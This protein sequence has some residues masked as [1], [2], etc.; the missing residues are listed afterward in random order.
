MKLNNKA[1]NILK[2]LV[3]IVLPAVA[4]L[5]TALSGV[6]GWPLTTEVSTSINAVTAFLG[7]VI[8][9]STANYNKSK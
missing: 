4:T 3:M 2:W 8:G 7:V 6:W 5:Y 1:Y 9:I